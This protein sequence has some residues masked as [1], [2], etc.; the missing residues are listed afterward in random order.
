LFI[1]NRNELFAIATTPT[2]PA[3]AGGK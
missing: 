1:V 2:A 3:S